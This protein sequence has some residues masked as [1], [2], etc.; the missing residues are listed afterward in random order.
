MSSSNF[1]PSLKTDWFSP[2][3]QQSGRGAYVQGS[4]YPAEEFEYKSSPKREETYYSDHSRY[5]DQGDIEIWQEPDSLLL[6][7]Y[8]DRLRNKISLW[9]KL[10]EEDDE[11]KMV[12]LRENAKTDR[13]LEEMLDRE[14]ANEDDDADIQAFFHHCHSSHTNT[15]GPYDGDKPSYKQ[16]HYFKSFKEACASKHRPK[17]GIFKIAHQR[18]FSM[19]YR[20]DSKGKGS[21]MTIVEV[22]ESPKNPLYT[23]IAF[24]QKVKELLEQ[25]DP[26]VDNIPIEIKNLI[27]E[28]KM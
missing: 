15:S 28:L 24:L 1:S 23:I 16:K 19:F 7:F 27:R 6:H 25:K 10:K 2:P 5:G 9:K 26:E 12:K 8:E 11:R 14:K 3:Q 21:T 4:T 18:K 17:Y 22:Q 20:D 13:F